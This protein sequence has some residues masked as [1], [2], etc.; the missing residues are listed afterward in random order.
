M[1]DDILHRLEWATY[2][3]NDAQLSSLLDDAGDELRRLRTAIEAIATCDQ[4]IAEYAKGV[5]DWKQ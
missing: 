1:G 4:P 5:I 3:Y 2:A